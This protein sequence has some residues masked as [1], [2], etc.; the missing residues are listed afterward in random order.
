MKKGS[1]SDIVER[2]KFEEEIT[3]NEAEEIEAET[4]EMK[5]YRRPKTLGLLLTIF[6]GI[7]IVLVGGLASYYYYTFQSQGTAGEKKLKQ[8]WSDTVADTNIL[9]T[10]L[11]RIDTFDKLGDTS[12]G[13]VVQVVNTTNQSV[14]DGLYDIKAVTGLNIKASTAASKLS[15]F[16]EDYS[17]MLLALKQIMGRAVD[18]TDKKDL[19]SLK[20]A[21]EQASK[22]Y[23]ELLLAGNGIVE[24]KLSRSIFSIPADLDALL[25]KKIGENRT[26]T[27]QQNAVKQASEQA[28]AQFVQAWGN[29]DAEGMSAKLTTGAKKDFSPVVVEESSDVTGFRVTNTTV[30]EDLSKATIVGQL[31]KK[32]PDEKTVTEIWEFGLLKQGEAWLIDDWGKQG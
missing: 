14:R 4:K 5:R 18:I 16:L 29:R 23:D 7:I 8:I 26:M 13:S 32:T 28:V 24:A 3:D 21:G 11:D 25:G 17:A 2:M 10:R 1:F 30:P 31:E 9:L 20:A 19:D 15:S 6:G 22:S 27:E 12:S